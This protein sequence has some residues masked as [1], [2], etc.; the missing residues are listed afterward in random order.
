MSQTM[1]N[2]SVPN[3][4]VP[5]A[6]VPNAT[7]PNTPAADADG[8]AQATRDA[9]SWRSIVAN[10]AIVWVVLALFIGL[11]LTTEAS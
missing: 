3:A 7:A 5:N 10:Y 6:S 8:E 2:A 11:S 4:S 1:P 9:R